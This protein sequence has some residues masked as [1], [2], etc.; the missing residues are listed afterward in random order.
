MIVSIIMPAYNSAATIST[1]ILSVI[2]QNFNS[3][4]LLIIDDFSSDNTK[5][6]IQKFSKYDSRIKLLSNLENKGPAYC[7]D[8]G[9][10]NS[11]GEYI[12]FLDSDD[13][14]YPNKLDKQ[15]S[16]MLKSNIEISYHSYDIIDSCGIKLKTIDCSI[17][18]LN[19]RNI[20]YIRNLG[21][22]LTFV[23]KKSLIEN[24]KFSDTSYQIAEDYLFFSSLLK[25]K[26]AYKAPLILA[27]YR[28]YTGSRSSNKILAAFYILYIYLYKENL[29]PFIAIFYWFLY[30]FHSI[31]NRLPS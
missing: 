30:I 24:I 10:S 29:N 8:L 16:W 18:I 6:I 26:N 1:S 13:I 28:N 19:Y 3:W 15:L 21:F 7:R 17:E 27:A 14:Y 22:C 4:E 11:L 20:H 9:I 25:K 31:K 2:S 12:A 5:S 23:I